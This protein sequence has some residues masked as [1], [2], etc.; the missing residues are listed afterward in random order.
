MEGDRVPIA[1]LVRV[2]SVGLPDRPVLDR[3]NLTGLFDIRLHFIEER[4]STPDSDSVNA[5]RNSPISP[6]ENSPAPAEWWLTVPS[7]LVHHGNCP[8][9]RKRAMQECNS[10]RNSRS[11]THQDDERLRGEAVRGRPR[12]PIK[13]HIGLIDLL[14]P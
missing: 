10:P 2:L 4:P 7:N 3:T 6:T 13:I 11:Q 12:S 9:K 5:N 8:V 1:E 14:M